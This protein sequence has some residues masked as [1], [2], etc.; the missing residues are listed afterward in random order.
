MESRFLMM[1]M[2]ILAWTF[3]FFD[4]L[5]LSPILRDS[6]VVRGFVVIGGVLTFKSIFCE[7]YLFLETHMS[8]LLR[9]VPIILSWELPKN[10][11]N[12]Q[13]EII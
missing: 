2:V 6:L 11:I 1:V 4:S 10:F 12:R 9:V 5:V 7:I 3:E 13:L 8:Y